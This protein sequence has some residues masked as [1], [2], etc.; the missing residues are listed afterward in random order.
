MSKITRQSVKKNVK[1]KS[2]KGKMSKVDNVEKDKIK[3][4]CY[5]LMIVY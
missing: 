5:K 3:N 2:I 4:R 1:D